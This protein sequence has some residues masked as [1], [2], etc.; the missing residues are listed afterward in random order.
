MSRNHPH[1]KRLRRRPG[2]SLAASLVAIVLL[3]IGVVAV[4]LSVARL[5][6]GAWPGLLDPVVQWFA[7]LTWNSPGAW[8]I[9]IAAVVIG[10]VLL[11]AALI[12]GKFSGM[13]VQAGRN[14]DRDTEA[15]L[16]N[17]ALTRLATAQAE[18]MDGVITSK[19]KA[20]GE[21]IRL[22]V[23]SPL[24]QPG[25]LRR[26]VAESVSERLQ[27]T[28]LVQKPKVGVRVRSISD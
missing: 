23:T 6:N 25:D 12:P 18:R 14:D 2:R 4:W 27:S 1:S 7:S 22:T 9:A 26:R 17:R 11:L 28:G 8:I 5:V 13:Q 10:L 3:A 15:L 19:A 20:K 16:S 21:K 24:R